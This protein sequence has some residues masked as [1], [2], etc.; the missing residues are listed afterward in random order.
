MTIT[1]VRSSSPSPAPAGGGD[2]R[3]PRKPDSPLSAAIQRN[4]G[5]I[6]AVGVAVLVLAFTV[7]PSMTLLVLGA[8][9]GI[10]VA[11]TALMVPTVALFLMVASEFANA[12]G[13]LVAL[14][15]SLYTSLL[16]L[17]VASAVIGLC[18][19]RYRDRIRPGWWIPAA[20]LL[21]YL[22][23][24]I[25]SAVLSQDP[26]STTTSLSDSLK[27][28]V[29]VVVMSLLL[30]MSGKPWAIIVAILIPLAI[31]SILTA[32]SEYVVGNSVTFGGFSTIQSD[33]GAD[34]AAARH[35]GPL[36]DPNFW[37]RFLILG[38]PFGLAAVTRALN[39]RSFLE[40][41]LAAAASL[42]VLLGIYLTQ[43]RGTM[44]AAGLAV[45]VWIIAA[46]PRIRRRAFFLAPLSLLILLLPGIGDRLLTLTQAVSSAPDYSADQ[47]LTERGNVGDVAFGVFKAN[48]LFGTG[49]GSFA[50]V[51]TH[52]AP[53][54]N[55]GP[56]GDI[57]A[58]HNLYLEILS[59]SGVV[60]MAG[61][62]VLVI[63]LLV[64]GYQATV[65]LAGSFPD[66]RGGR[67]TR[68]TAAAGVAAIVGFSAA[69]IFLHLAYSRTF[70]MVGALIGY[71]YTVSRTDR[72]LTRPAP[73]RATL[74]ARKGFVFATAVTV[75]T[76]VAA[77]VVGATLYSVLGTKTYVATSELTLQ[78]TGA[79]YPGYAMDVRRRVVTLPAYASVIQS[80]GAN[81]DTTVI[82]DP[83]RGVMT[84]E[85]VADSPAEA[86][87]RRDAIVTN[88]PTAIKQSSL[89]AVY[90]VVTVSVGD[91]TEKRVVDGTAMRVILLATAA[92]IALVLF[93]CRRIRSEER[94]RGV[95]LI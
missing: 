70:L 93:L 86:I 40:L 14:P 79:G 71:M 27:D 15:L 75:A 5:Y 34:I 64:L 65:R 80:S 54:T 69:S 81:Q 12:S 55:A 17:C 9:V 62:A 8:L 16:G 66:A 84:V 67:L 61:W 2:P 23:T 90:N 22:V 78:A 72:D 73:R 77:L 24:L 44:L 11:G 41:F 45:V 51:M 53:L 82:A 49:P 1:Q 31:I 7:G 39:R 68:A 26:A 83:T 58:T 10:G 3:G 48:P 89:D 6:A 74:Q 37:G 59:E 94:R 60:G 87:R 20:L 28:L 35:S 52:Y 32:M 42:S 13:V 57:T 33:A 63:G 47:S 18:R 46:G 43:S 88:A 95:W 38:L 36:P 50:D 25:P 92:E 76:A 19:K 30:Q 91:V 21:A 56:T 85:A 29:F 4:G